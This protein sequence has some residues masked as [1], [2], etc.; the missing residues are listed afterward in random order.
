MKTFAKTIAVISIAFGTATMANANTVLEASDNSASTEI[1][2]TATQGSKLKLNQ[3]IKEAG[4]T[5]REAVEL[6]KCN[7]ET[8][9]DFVEQ[10]GANVVS[11]NDYITSGQYSENMTA[12]VS[13]H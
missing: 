4:L 7:G 3:A 8:L 9:V 11:I 13:A 1:C 2:M 10:H 6:V 5:K 12:K